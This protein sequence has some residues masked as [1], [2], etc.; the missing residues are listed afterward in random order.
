MK[1][2]YTGA[3][4]ACALC[5]CIGL[6]GSVAGIARADDALRIDNLMRTELQVAEGVE[7][8]VSVIEIGPGFSLPKHYHPGEEFV[9]VLEGS[10]TVWQ[11]GKPDVV[12]RA[13]DAFKVPLQQVHT[14]MTSDISARAVIFRV[15]K[16]GA[17]DRIPVE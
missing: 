5:I 14:A 10:A 7:V 4:L 9:Y 17:P 13:G 11:Q 1:R 2:I 3:G 6:G 8:I 12:L 15:H 16:K